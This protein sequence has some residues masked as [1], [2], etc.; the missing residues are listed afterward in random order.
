VYSSFILGWLGGRR[1][2]H[3]IIYGRLFMAAE[4]I[5]FTEAEKLFPLCAVWHF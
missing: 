4:C 3:G 5:L 1:K 2:W